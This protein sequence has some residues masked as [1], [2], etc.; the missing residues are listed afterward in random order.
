V[1]SSLAE[2]M[3]ELSTVPTQILTTDSTIAKADK[4]AH[5][6]DVAISGPNNAVDAPAGAIEPS[7]EAPRVQSSLT[8]DKAEPSTVPT[9]LVTTDAP[10]LKPNEAAHEPDVAISEPNNAV[11]APVGANQ[12]SNETPRVESSLTEDTTEPSTVPTQTVAT[13]PTIGTVGEAAYAV[14]GVAITGPNNE[15]DAPAGAIQPRDEASPVQSSLTEETIEP[16][17][18]VATD[19]AIAKADDAH[20]DAG[21]RRD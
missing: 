10:I 15:A 20:D 17:T 13:E 6:P 18:V 1:Q 8:E 5:E 7:D 19:L 21:R 3:A 4:A 11:D 9:A 14:D 16:S 12:P 2:D